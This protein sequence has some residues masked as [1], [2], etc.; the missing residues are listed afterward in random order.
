MP[1][2]TVTNRP[3]L[4]SIK[5]PLIILTVF[6]V[7]GYCVQGVWM[8]EKQATETIKTKHRVETEEPIWDWL[9]MLKG[10]RTSPPPN[11]SLLHEDHFLIS[12]Y[13]LKSFS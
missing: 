3:V 10:F 2:I 4:L 13:F 5:R 7:D 8:L 11:M 6:S 1:N 9:L 12:I